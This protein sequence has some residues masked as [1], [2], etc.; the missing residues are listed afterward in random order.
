[1]TA[2]YLIVRDHDHPALPLAMSLW[3]SQLFEFTKRDQMSLS[4]ALWKVG[5]PWVF[6]DDSARIYRQDIT[7]ARHHR[8]LWR[9]LVTRANRVFLTSKYR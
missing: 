8:S 5:L 4:Y 1:V 9:R 6:L 2:N 3:W 7:R